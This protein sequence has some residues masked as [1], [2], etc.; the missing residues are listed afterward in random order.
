MSKHN[1][2][3]EL[4]LHPSSSA[5][6]DELQDFESGLD[7]ARQA[8]EPRKST[9]KKLIFIGIIAFLLFLVIVFIAVTAGKKK[10]KEYSEGKEKKAAEQKAQNG[11]SPSNRKAI[12]FADAVNKKR[13][14]KKPDD[15]VGTEKVT[16]DK[17]AKSIKVAGTQT[18]G[19]QV[20]GTQTEGTQVQGA[21][22]KRS[23]PPPIPSMMLDDGAPSKIVAI[24]DNTSQG[25]SAAQDPGQPQGKRQTPQ[26]VM[27][28]IERIMGRSNNSN[29]MTGLSA[30]AAS[31]ATKSTV[32]AARTVQEVALLTK[33]G[34]LTKT[35]QVSAANLGNRD[36]VITRGKHLSCVLE[37]QIVSNLPGTTAC[38]LT[39][40]IYSANGRVLLLEKGTR[41]VGS[42]QSGM[43]LGDVRLAIV[44]DRLE[45]PEGIVIDVESPSADMVGASGVPGHVDN[46][47]AERIGAAFLLS[48]VQD[49][50]KYETQKATGQTYQENNNGNNGNQF[51]GMAATSNDLTKKVLDSTINIPPLMVKNR[52]DI[53]NI[54]VRHDL[55]FQD[56]YKVKRK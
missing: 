12:S 32:P 43:K 19:T 7:P 26:E 41:A 21:N 44:W 52:G 33:D 2:E 24:A 16:D 54:E 3:L 9:N 10:Y 46:R 5:A 30:P 47:W 17:N 48:F 37:T 45:S 14:E 51:G 15:G 20:Q 22:K 18:E 25:Y 36:Y 4:D 55:W 8:I 6:P 27:S 56:V 31:N 29:D 53:I 40:N 1:N 13:A 35:K 49:Y 38:I 23:E 28:S 11:E 50:I 34:G 39:E 42:Y